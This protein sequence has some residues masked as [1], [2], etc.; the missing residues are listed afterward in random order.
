[1]VRPKIEDSKAGDAL[2]RQALD[3]WIMPEIER[4]RSA[5]QLAERFTLRAAQVVMNIDGGVPRVR[6][7]EEVQIVLKVRFGPLPEAKQAGEMIVLDENTA[8]EDME[9]TDTD[10]NA[11]HV[12][13]LAQGG[14]WHIKFDFRYNSERCRDTLQIAREFLDAAASALKK[15]NL[16][17]F[18]DNLFSA[19]ELM[20]KAELLMLPD[21]AVLHCHSHGVISP[22]Y[23]WWGKLGNTDHQYVKLLN[24]LS[25]LR[26][27]ARYGPM[28][29]LNLRPDEPASMLKTARKMMRRVSSFIPERAKIPR[30]L[31]GGVF[32]QTS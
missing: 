24:R 2:M 1:M 20:A 27:L 30:N 26:K 13:M 23:N 10:P 16:S 21:K 8:I 29:R 6:L 7:N 14:R 28:S 5:T 17:A 31:K 18:V 22:R 3:L 19:T 12:T 4:R 25:S 9:L 32:S 15:G 11:G